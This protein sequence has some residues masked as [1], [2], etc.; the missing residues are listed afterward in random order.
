[1][2][3]EHSFIARL[4]DL[5]ERCLGCSQQTNA[6]HCVTQDRCN[7]PW[8]NLTQNSQAKWQKSIAIFP[9]SCIWSSSSFKGIQDAIGRGAATQNNAIFP[10]KTYFSDTAS[11]WEIR[12]FFLSFFLILYIW[13]RAYCGF[14]SLGQDDGQ[15]RSSVGG[16]EAVLL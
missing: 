3:K 9:F 1:M 14:L 10:T 11:E 15:R 4:F 13:S 7:T 5:L 16:Q 8:S 6:S 12:S 2:T